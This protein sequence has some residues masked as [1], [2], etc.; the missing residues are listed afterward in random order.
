MGFLA[1]AQA[2]FIGLRETKSYHE[3]LQ[4]PPAKKSKLLEAQ[5][6]IRRE[7]RKKSGRIRAEDDF[8]DRA[9]ITHRTHRLRPDI[10]PK[11]FTQGSVAY[12]LLIDPVHKPL[13]QLDLDDGMYVGVD[14]LENGQPVLVAKA[15]FRFVEEAIAPL[16]KE[17]GWKIDATKQTC[18]R[19]V[20]NEESHLDIPIYSAPRQQLV[21]M[22]AVSL[23]TRA[24][25]VIKRAGH[26]YARLPPDKI[27]LAHR[28]GA[29]E[30]SDPL[31]L[32]DWVAA[33]V[34]R[35]GELFR[36]SCRYFKGW[37]DH[38]WPTGSLTSI[39]IMAAIVQTLEDMN[40]THRDLDDDK[41]VYEIAR[42]LP[43]T[44]ESDICNPAFQDGSK[45]LNNWSPEKRRE[46]VSATQVLA[47]HIHDALR[48]TG[49]P[50]LVVEAL[51]RAFGHRIPYRPDAVRI[52]SHIA[53]TVAAEVA[54]RVPIP[55][56]TSS[57]SG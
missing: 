8:W 20:L 57:T 32:S 33:C 39:T 10:L 14:Y 30:R 28:S 27:M 36:R 41:L 54:A 51:Q 26:E 4:V 45:I 46:I 42:R 48:G 44:F 34:E 15:L 22:D 17:R 47:G 12:D 49:V 35:Y 52:E 16:C 31:A 21:A 56:V 38:R 43:Q 29:W 6:A 40:G 19:I 23:E 50:E 25:S 24:D 11:F 18:V 37:R 9:S 3:A 55:R 1:S 53:T 13:Q 5:Q 2:L 7:I